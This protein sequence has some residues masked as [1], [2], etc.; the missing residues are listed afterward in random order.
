MDPKGYHIQAKETST[1]T[2]S[3]SKELPT[4]P[5]GG[6]EKEKEDQVERTDLK[7]RFG[8]CVFLNENDPS[9]YKS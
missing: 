7:L 1:I 9:S 5:T 4:P 2:E 6:K 8:E 3:F